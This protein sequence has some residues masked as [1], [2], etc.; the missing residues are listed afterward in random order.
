MKIELI[1][2][3]KN[4]EKF[5][6]DGF[7]FYVNKIKHYG[8]LEFIVLIPSKEIRKK[9]IIEQKRDEAM[10]LK[11][12][13]EKGVFRILLDEK[14]EK[15]SSIEVSKL[16]ERWMARSPKKIQFYI[17]GPFGVDLDFK[18][19]FDFILS[20]SDMTFSHQLVRLMFLEQLYRSFTI[21]KGEKYHH[22]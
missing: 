11:K 8:K 3:E 15:I 20:F 16:L 4:S 1:M 2:I 6:N 18:K 5:I 17:G 13:F 22:E 12:H 21:I 10:L 14:G 7:D 19:E 9:S